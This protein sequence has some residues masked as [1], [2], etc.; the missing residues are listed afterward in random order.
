MARQKLRCQLTALEISFL[1][2]L[3]DGLDV[4]VGRICLRRGGT[5]GSACVFLLFR[6]LYIAHMRSNDVDSVSRLELVSDCKCH[7]GGLVSGEAIG[8]KVIS[9]STVSNRKRR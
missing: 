4:E 3:G 8:I 7:E 6:G 5:R 2:P 1:C 9:A